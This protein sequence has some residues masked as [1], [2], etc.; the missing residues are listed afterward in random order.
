M[1]LLIGALA[2]LAISTASVLEAD[3]VGIYAATFD[4]PTQARL[5]ILRCALGDVD[6][7]KDC[8]NLGKNI[9][10]LF[11]LVRE[12]PNLDTLASTRERTLMVKRALK[13]YGAR[14]QV[15]PASSPE[16]EEKKRSLFADKTIDKVYELADGATPSQTPAPTLLWDAKLETVVFPLESDG[17]AASPGNTWDPR[18]DQSVR[19]VMDQLG[20]YRQ[21]SADLDPLQRA[22]FEEGWNDFLDDLKL[23]C[24]YT[25]Q[26]DTCD[27]LSSG[28]KSISIT[29]DSGNS[30]PQR[31]APMIGSALIYKK[32]QSEDRWAEKFV[33]AALRR[34][35]GTKSYAK[36]E[37]VAED[38][39][40]RTLQGY[41]RGKV[42]HL[43]RV[44]IPAIRPAQHPVKVASM[45]VSCSAP[46]GTYNMDID[47]Y[48][49]DRFP[50]AFTEFLNKDY[51]KHSQ[52]PVELYVHNDTVE[53]SYEFHA[54]D[55]FDTFYFL[56]TRR[57]QLHRNIHLAIKSQPHA[58]R[59]VLT[60]VRGND[61][62]AN[63][64]CQIHRA[65][66]F[67]RFHFVQSPHQEPLF[68]LNATGKSLK[69]SK[70]DW[71]LFGFRGSWRRTLQANG[72]HMTS[73]IERGLD[74]DLF[75]YPA[76]K[77]KIVTVRN[78]FGDDA[79]IVLDTFYQKGA[80]RII[81]LGIAGAIQ[82][83]QVGDVVIPNEFV[84]RSGDSVPFASNLAQ[85]YEKQVATLLPVHGR[86]IQAWVPH[87]YE[88]TISVLKN[89]KA[90]SVGAVDIEGIY[91][92]RF[93][94]RHNDAKM[95]ALYVIS[96]Q[97]L[98]KNTIEDTNAY[99][100]LID[101]SV[102]KIVS[103]LFPEVTRSP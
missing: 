13:T 48:T 8:R 78:V 58:Y 99:R 67:S 69:L 42:P 91:L 90:H 70:N 82:D 94:R 2:M 52:V 76:V 36:L 100:A 81:Y 54:R 92:G 62:R 88:E 102:D 9:S 37:E 60:D 39:A 75:T 29:A 56:Q 72:W 34:L 51:R 55:G 12:D 44:V 43:K 57:G 68:V 96:D 95:A 103:F 27:E 28:W 49:A 65:G 97:T 24:P 64:L 31:S 21:V 98:G 20:L 4:P 84:D 3:S 59:V 15:L 19:E 33:N 35:R 79:N 47:Q 80:R 45:P 77:Q 14:V 85:S 63:V 32:A 22:L 83:Y 89:W 93:A 5:R 26:R 38:I 71:L 17:G 18:V 66:V 74:V 50:R 40:A 86:T 87:L 1:N 6:L 101:E 16:A 53:N 46:A 7:P 61:R 73:L 23:A 11:V 30:H 25:I 10:R 41:P